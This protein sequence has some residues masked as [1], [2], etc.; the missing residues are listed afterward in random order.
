MLLGYILLGCVPVMVRAL[1]DLG[2]HS[3]DIVT[4]RFALGFILTL[5]LA[6]VGRTR[7]VSEQPGLLVLRGLLGAIAVQLYFASVQL[8]G[9]GVG[10]LLNYT[11]PV[12][13]NVLGSFFGHRPARATWLILLIATFGA[14][15]VVDPVFSSMS[16]GEAYG[17]LSALAAG[18]SIVCIKKLR[19]TDSEL[20]VLAGF[21][22]IGSLAGIA[23]SVGRLN[24]ASTPL[25]TATARASALLLG[26]AVLSFLGHVLFTRGY[27]RTSIQVGSVLSFTVPVTAMLTGILLL[28]ERPSL[29]VYAGATLILCACLGTGRLP[30]SVHSQPSDTKRRRSGPVKTDSSV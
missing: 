8:S 28:G 9:A 27:K 29:S 20:T 26:V 23:L 5:A 13:A 24:L 6:F 16:L 14:F 25:P 15:L 11:Y 12:W 2:L 17:L 1:R 3:T 7:L 21:C 18:G 19:Q 30:T 22:G 10:T 4:I